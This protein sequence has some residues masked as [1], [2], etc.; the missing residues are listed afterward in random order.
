MLLSLGDGFP[1]RNAK[2]MM[3]DLQ[4]VTRFTAPFG[5]Y[6]IIAIILEI[7]LD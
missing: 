6:S 2:N 7:E 1:V 3:S 5:F 4:N